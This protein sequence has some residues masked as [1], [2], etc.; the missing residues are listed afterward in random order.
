MFL[1]VLLYYGHV[2]IVSH[3]LLFWMI[4]NLTLISSSLSVLSPRPAGGRSTWTA[5]ACDL[6]SYYLTG[7]SAVVT[8]KVLLYFF[9]PKMFHLTANLF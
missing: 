1:F 7:A 4:H 8:I 2:H 6:I 3:P 9:K 5:T